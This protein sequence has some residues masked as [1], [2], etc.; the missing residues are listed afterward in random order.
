MLSDISPICAERGT[1]QARNS[2]DCNSVLLT[3][4]PSP[5]DFSPFSEAAILLGQMRLLFTFPVL[6]Q[7]IDLHWDLTKC[8]QVQDEEQ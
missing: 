5:A 7:Q 3:D 1:I 6:D 4:I 8:P 2:H